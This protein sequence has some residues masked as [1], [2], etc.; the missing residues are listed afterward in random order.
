MTWRNNTLRNNRG[1]KHGRGK[2]DATRGARGL[3]RVGDRR[4]HAR[5]TR[6]SLGRLPG[7]ASRREG[8]STI[9]HVV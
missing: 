8:I 5:S 6:L 9:R 1:R 4:C 7:N 3:F 2:I